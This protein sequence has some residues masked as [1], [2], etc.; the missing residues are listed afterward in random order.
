MPLLDNVDVVAEVMRGRVP[1]AVARRDKLV[2]LRSE[3]L[4]MV[5]ELDLV[6]ARASW[7]VLPL[8]GQ[9]GEAGWL[10]VDGELLQ[11][12]WLV[13]ASGELTGVACAA[14][15]IGSKLEQQVSRLFE[16]RKASL[17]VVLDGVG[18]ELLFALSRRVQ[19]RMFAGVRRQ[20]LTMAGEL[21][22]GDPG[23]ALSAQQTV[24]R[25]ADAQSIGVSVTHTQMMNPTKSTSIVHGVG[26]DL[27]KASWSRCDDCRSRERCAIARENA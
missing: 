9:P 7:R 4:A 2:A 14:L 20:G 18:N 26:R 6:Q 22:A 12:P 24:L 16:Q 17:A 8:E 3:A 27:P 23:L 10:C 15:T 5:G 21:R 13:P 19:D 25:L 11:A 1:A